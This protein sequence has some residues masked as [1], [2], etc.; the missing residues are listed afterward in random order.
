MAPGTVL[1]P[2][3]EVQ[4]LVGCWCLHRAAVMVHP[5]ANASRITKKAREGEQ[6]V[7]G[8]GTIPVIPLVPSQSS[9]V[10]GDEGGG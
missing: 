2:G 7:P 6:S 9:A 5:N 10:P 1:S 8:A 3:T 4:S